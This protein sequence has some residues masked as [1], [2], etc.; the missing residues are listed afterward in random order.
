MMRY[1][2]R[3]CERSRQHTGGARQ[4]NEC[5]VHGRAAPNHRTPETRITMFAVEPIIRNERNG[6]MRLALRPDETNRAGGR[7]VHGGGTTE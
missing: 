6:Q 2:R 3:R 1:K 5:N 4:R 7:V